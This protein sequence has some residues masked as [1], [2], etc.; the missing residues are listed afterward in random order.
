MEAT[1]A[2]VYRGKDTENGTGNPRDAY[3]P[4]D[5]EGDIHWCQNANDSGVMSH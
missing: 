3:L 1:I 2:Y 4:K 5:V